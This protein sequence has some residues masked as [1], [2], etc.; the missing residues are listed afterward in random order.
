[1]KRITF[2]I[3]SLTAVLVLITSCSSNDP[4]GA[5]ADWK[6]KNDT[7]F[8][9]YKDSTGYVLYTIPASSGGGSFYY[10]VSVAGDPN[11]VSPSVDEQVLVNYRGKMINGV[12]FDQTYQGKILQGDTTAAPRVFYTKQLIRGWIENLKQMKNGEVRTI[13]LPQELGY[14]S[15]GVS[16]MISPYSTTIWVV[17][18]VSF[19]HVN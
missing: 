12:V 14:G 17:Q 16:H 6:I 3:L 7:Y 1:M 9:N 4:A 5:Y 18:L 2:N 15:V 10:K 13:V 19:N 11:S 8:T